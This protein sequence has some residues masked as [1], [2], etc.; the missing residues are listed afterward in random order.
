VLR[1]TGLFDRIATEGCL[2]V[3]RENPFIPGLTDCLCNIENDE[4]NILIMRLE[5]AGLIQLRKSQ[6]ENAAPTSCGYS[7][8]AHPLIR[9]YFGHKLK[10]FHPDAYKT[11]HT[12]LFEHLISSVDFWPNTLLTLQPLYQA[13]VHGC[14]AKLYSVV[15]EKIYIGRILRGLGHGPNDYYSSK[16]LGAVGADLSSVA[17][18]FDEPWSL[19]TSDLDSKHRTWLLNEA[20]YLL[21]ILGRLSEAIEPMKIACSDICSESDSI[22]LALRFNNLCELLAALGDFGSSIEAGKE[23]ISLADRSGDQFQRM[24]DRVS[25]ADAMHQ[26]GNRRSARMLFEEAELLQASQDSHHPL[27]NGGRGYRFTDLILAPAEVAAWKRV[28]GSFLIP[29]MEEDIAVNACEEVE[30]RCNFTIIWVTASSNELLAPALE[31]LNHIRIVLFRALNATEVE[32]LVKDGLGIPI[33][34]TI[35]NI[36]ITNLFDRLPKALLVGAL[37][38]GTLGENPEEAKRLLEEAQQIAERGPMPLYL[39]DVHLHRARLFGRLPKSDRQAKFPDI[40]PK[41]ELAEARRLI[42]KHGYWRRKE[43]LEDAEVAAANW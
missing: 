2:T 35:E 39:A 38:H 10:M 11:A 43:E 19:V 13:V 30:R 16:K 37:Y 41:A 9:E 32:D 20:A 24:N 6:V 36:R 31:E 15:L 7:I 27:L 28:N 29:Q 14:L 12:R 34:K 25:T 4:W 23:A 18:F 17:T 22:T 8:D 33:D 40:D 3:L 42:E 1:L 5:R 26:N 21:R